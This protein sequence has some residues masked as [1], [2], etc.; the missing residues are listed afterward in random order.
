MI[1]SYFATRYDED[2]HTLDLP[3]E[4]TSGR[5][6]G[7]CIVDQVIRGTAIVGRV[8]GDFGAVALKVRGTGKAVHVVVSIQL[9][10]LSTRW[11]SDRMQPPRLTPERPRLVLLRAQGE[12]K[13]ATLLAR[14]QAW[15]RAG[16]STAEIG[17]DLTADELD[18][19]A[20][21]S[22]RSPRQRTRSG[23]AAGSPARRHWACASTG[24]RCASRATAIRCGS[25]TARPAAIWP[26]CRRTRRARSAST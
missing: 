9:D 14:R 23:P 13:G 26:S 18:R 25:A 17:F 20:S 19:T 5:D 4:V 3:V 1:G 2:R 15:R 21:S 6:D 8:T 7:L 12:L 11:W 10:D 24:S 22:S 16:N